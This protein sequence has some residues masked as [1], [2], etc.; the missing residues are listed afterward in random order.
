MKL[1]VIVLSLLVASIY[2]V[3]DPAFIDLPFPRDLVRFLLDFEGKY[4]TLSSDIG[5]LA[6]RCNNCGPGAYPDSLGVHVT[7]S[8]APAYAKFL[9]SHYGQGVTLQADT[10]KF[11]SRC[12]N[13]WSGGAYPDAAFIHVTT[14]A[15]NP[16]AVWSPVQ[17]NGKWTFRADSGKFLARCRNCVPGGA[18]PDFAFVHEPNNGNPWAQWTVT[19][20]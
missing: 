17:V 19:A 7:Q 16:W 14:P 11:V 13:C 15:G 1:N 3:Q 12:N 4:V 2:S 9:V 8:P 6:S 5:N 20:A 10:G 18:Y